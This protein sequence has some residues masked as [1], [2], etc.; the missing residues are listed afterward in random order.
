MYKKVTLHS[1]PYQI[2]LKVRLRKYLMIKIQPTA[3]SFKAITYATQKCV[4]IG[5]MSG[6]GGGHGWCT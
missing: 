5:L 1:K 3:N 4:W 2:I 6:G